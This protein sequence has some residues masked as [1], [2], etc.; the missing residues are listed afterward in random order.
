MNLIVRS[1]ARARSQDQL[2]LVEDSLKANLT[3]NTKIALE[4]AGDRREVCR[5]SRTTLSVRAHASISCLEPFGKHVLF[6][7]LN[8]LPRCST[9]HAELV[10]VLIELQRT[11]LSCKPTEAVEGRTE[12]RSLPA[13]EDLDTPWCR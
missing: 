7:L 9:R 8:L 5:A 11:L 4:E 6:I 3:P 13:S 1:H 12:Y 2:N 10:L